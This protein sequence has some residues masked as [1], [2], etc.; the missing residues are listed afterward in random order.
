LSCTE[1]GDFLWFDGS[2]NE[3]FEFTSE[4]FGLGNHICWLQVINTQDCYSIDSV[5]IGVKRR[6]VDIPGFTEDK[7]LFIYPNPTTGILNLEFKSRKETAV[8][9]TIS[10]A[11]G[12]VIFLEDVATLGGTQRHQLDLS[13]YRDGVYI[14]SVNIDG[15]PG[16]YKVVLH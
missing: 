5:T 9:I 14:L 1:S 16:I 4:A 11:Q 6:P 13:G 8:K 10:D 12:R 7:F 2:R 3:Y 15:V